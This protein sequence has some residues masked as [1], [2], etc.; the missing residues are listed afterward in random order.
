MSSSSVVSTGRPTATRAEEALPATVS[1]GETR[2]SAM[3]L[4]MISM[5]GAGSETTART[6]APARGVRT[7]GRGSDRPLP[8]PAG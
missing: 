5:A 3:G 6:S 4:S 2:W 1:A 7:A 8:R